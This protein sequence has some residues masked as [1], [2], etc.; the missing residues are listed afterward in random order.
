MRVRSLLFDGVSGL[1]EVNPPGFLPHGRPRVHV[2]DDTRRTT[3]ASR[4]DRATGSRRDALRG[5]AICN[6][7]A[8]L[9][10]VPSRVEENPRHGGRIELRKVTLE[11]GKAEG[12]EAQGVHDD[13]AGCP[14][15]TLH[16]EQAHVDGASGEDVGRVAG[17]EQ[18]Q[19]SSRRHDPLRGLQ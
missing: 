14:A 19:P 4:D 18:L 16:V 17:I 7:V 6:D 1:S 13:L 12:A 2:E 15:G 8:A 10:D 9:E 3:S 5:V 11:V